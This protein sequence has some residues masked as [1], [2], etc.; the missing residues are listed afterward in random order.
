MPVVA[1]CVLEIKVIFELW[2]GVSD[3]QRFLA[4]AAISRA[5]FA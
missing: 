1:E 5:A 2:S 3:A 4:A